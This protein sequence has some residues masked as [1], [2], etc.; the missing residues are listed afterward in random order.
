MIKQADN[1]FPALTHL[2][3]DTFEDWNPMRYWRKHSALSHSRSHSFASQKLWVC[4]K[5]H[6]AHYQIKEHCYS[7]KG[8]LDGT[9]NRQ[10][11]EVYLILRL[12]W[13]S[14]SQNNKDSSKQIN[15]QLL[16]KAKPLGTRPPLKPLIRFFGKYKKWITSDNSWETSRSLLIRA[17]CFSRRSGS[18]NLWIESPNEDQI[19]KRFKWFH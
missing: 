2:H 11:R 19:W 1:S 17:A 3:Q 14:W 16:H 5:H 4:Q 9:G 8:R 10:V 12:I 15:K 7:Y 6:A 13:P 18:F